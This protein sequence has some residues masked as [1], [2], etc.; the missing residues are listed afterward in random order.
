MCHPS[1]GAKSWRFSVDELQITWGNSPLFERKTSCLWKKGEGDGK[2]NE[3]ETVFVLC[4]WD[5]VTVYSDISQLAAKGFPDLLWIWKKNLKLEH[6]I[7]KCLHLGVHIQLQTFFSFPIYV[8][9]KPEIPPTKNPF[10]KKKMCV[11]PIY[12]WMRPILDL[13][14]HHD[15]R[16]ALKLFANDGFE[17]IM[18]NVCIQGRQDIVHKNHLKGHP[19]WI[20][21]GVVGR[22]GGI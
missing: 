14:C 12:R 11:A 2:K 9:P 13:M 7:P 3:I 20:C 10:D 19:R 15:A 22:K 16:L 5:L 6:S 21:R 8:E 17:D 4:F 18:P 1:W